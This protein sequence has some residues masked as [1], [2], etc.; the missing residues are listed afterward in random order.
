M[1][2]RVSSVSI[3]KVR[4]CPTWWE[5]PTKRPLISEDLLLPTWPCIECRHRV[6]YTTS[7]N[8]KHSRMLMSTVCPVNTSSGGLHCSDFSAV[9][10][11]TSAIHSP[12]QVTKCLRD[13]APIHVPLYVLFE[14]FPTMFCKVLMLVIGSRSASRRCIGHVE[15]R[16]LVW[17]FRR[18]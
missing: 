8:R 3:L 7:Q 1:I 12:V 11:I 4:A 15:F 2:C 6:T 10:F 14:D 18:E 9:W 13:V 17:K 5:N 16:R